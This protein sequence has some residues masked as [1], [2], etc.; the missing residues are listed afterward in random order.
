MAIEK[1][2]NIEYVKSQI[3]V[4]KKVWAWFN[5]E[6]VASGRDLRELVNE[7]LEE[8]AERQTKARA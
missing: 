4:K 3:F 5:Y 7:A 8:Y 6:K 2:N 1:I